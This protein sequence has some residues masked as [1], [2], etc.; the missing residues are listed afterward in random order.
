MAKKIK[1]SAEKKARILRCIL[2]RLHHP[3]F[4]GVPLAAPIFIP[5][6]TFLEQAKGKG[7]FKGEDNSET[8]QSEV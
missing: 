8:K 2:R 1:I 3:D 5:T 7:L 4:R 6:Q